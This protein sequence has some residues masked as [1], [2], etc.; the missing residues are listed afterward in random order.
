MNHR[1]PLMAIRS[2]TIDLGRTQDRVQQAL[3]GERAILFASEAGDIDGYACRRERP[4]VT[5]AVESRDKMLM[6]HPPVGK[7]E[8]EDKDDT[9]ETVIGSDKGTT[10]GEL[11]QYGSSTWKGKY[12]GLLKEVKRGTSKC[13]EVAPA[14]YFLDQAASWKR[15]DGGVDGITG[16]EMLAIFNAEPEELNTDE[17]ESEDGSEDFSYLDDIDREYYDYDDAWYSDGEDEDDI[18]D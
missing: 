2:F 1:L 11:F 16:H 9:H 4:G 5:L 18:Y 3:S 15:L 7:L 13:E 17:S 6:T 12:R 8:L 14:V 10:L